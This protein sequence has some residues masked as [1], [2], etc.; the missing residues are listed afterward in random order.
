MYE[1]VCLCGQPVLLVVEGPV[2]A[3]WGKCS[4]GR[5]WMLR[6]MSGRVSFDEPE[7]EGLVYEA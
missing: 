7:P 5:Q 6:E 4:C 2:E 1:I 3:Y